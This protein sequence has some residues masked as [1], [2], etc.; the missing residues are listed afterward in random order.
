M[1]KKEFRRIEAMAAGMDAV[2]ELFTYGGVNGDPDGFCLGLRGSGATYEFCPGEDK[3]GDFFE[4]LNDDFSEDDEESRVK[5]FEKFCALFSRIEVNE[6]RDAWGNPWVTLALE[7]GY[8]SLWL[9]AGDEGSADLMLRTHIHCIERAL[10]A[11]HSNDL[12]KEKE[13]ANY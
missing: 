6:R 11:L 7:S 5:V 13:N 10:E 9:T 1:D 8:S 2:D 12:E 4:A 3:K